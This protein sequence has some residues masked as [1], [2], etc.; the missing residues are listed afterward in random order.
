MKKLIQL[1][2]LFCFFAV[3]S[4][5]AQNPTAQSLTYEQWQ[6]TTT[7]FTQTKDVDD[8]SIFTQISFKQN[9]Q[10]INIADCELTVLRV[11]NGV[12]FQLYRIK[13]ASKYSFMFNIP[14]GALQKQY[15]YILYSSTA[16]RPGQPQYATKKGAFLSVKQ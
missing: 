6:T 4:S 9:N 5:E 1:V 15:T 8:G 16:D 12:L 11:E 13:P 2:I 3:I 10:L 7:A 14:L